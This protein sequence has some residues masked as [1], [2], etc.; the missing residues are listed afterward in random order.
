MNTHEQKLTRFLLSAAMVCSAPAGRSEEGPPSQEPSG[1]TTAQIL[2]QDKIRMANELFSGMIGRDLDKVLK[3]AEALKLISKATSWHRP[4]DAEFNFNARSFQNSTESLIENA[5]TKNY[6]GLGM[7]Y[8][9]L[10]LAC[11]NCHNT[12]RFAE[13]KT[14]QTKPKK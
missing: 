3:S 4:N 12:T 10:T 11:M 2:M 6:E 13:R 7:S 8:F 9:R 1:K 5:Q 14:P